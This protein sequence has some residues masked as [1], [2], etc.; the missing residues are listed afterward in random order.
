MMEAMTVEDILPFVS[1][2]TPKERVR[3]LRLITERHDADD[4]AVYAAVPP[5]RD[6]FF[7]AEDALG[8]EADGWEAVD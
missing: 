2:L 7:S 5:R 6:E 4:A 1:G 8:W 3:L